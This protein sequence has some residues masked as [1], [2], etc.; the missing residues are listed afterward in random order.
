MKKVL[1]LIATIV[2]A[3]FGGCSATDKAYDK[4]K[5]VYT[6]G[7]TVYEVVPMK[8]KRVEAIGKTAE[9]YDEARTLLKD[10]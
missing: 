4:A 5:K 6:T 3:L 1:F 10:D 8:S 7:K 9:K 2:I